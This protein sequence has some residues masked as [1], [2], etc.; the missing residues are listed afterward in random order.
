[1]RQSML[2]QHLTCVNDDVVIEP[3]KHLIVK[4]AVSLADQISDHVELQCIINPLENLTLDRPYLRPTN[5]RLV[6]RM[7]FSFMRS[8]NNA[9]SENT[10]DSPRGSDRYNEV[11]EGKLKY[12]ENK[13]GNNSHA[14]Y[15][16]ASGAPVEVNSPLGYKV[17]A[18]T[19]LFLNLSK[20]IGTGIF[21]TR[22][23]GDAFRSQWHCSPILIAR[24]S[25]FRIHRHRICRAYDDILVHRL[26]CVGSRL[27]NLL[28]KEWSGP[29]ATW[30]LAIPIPHLMT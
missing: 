7:P 5:S 26:P 22:E 30:N 19:I 9:R 11:S 3:V 10:L 15:Q 6:L 16:E 4:T 24:C 25:L 27:V 29:R 13:G 2:L 23:F 20:M 12:V 18:I 28:T 17:G 14:S 1:M 8:R 21:S